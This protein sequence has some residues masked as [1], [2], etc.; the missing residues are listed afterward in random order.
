MID[1]RN[2]SYTGTFWENYL[3]DGTPADGS[4]SLSHGWSS[5]PT[6]TLTGYVLGVQAVDPGYRSFTVAPHFG[7]LNW[8]KGTV[9][10]P[11]GPISVAWTRHGPGYT[12]TVQ[13][14][15]GTTA[16]IEVG[17]GRTATVHGTARTVTAAA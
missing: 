5:G 11:Y 14:P 13:A 9:P 16:T 7:S 10:T 8:A 2:P 4:I 6:P 1:P 15:P 17:G 12:L 3:P